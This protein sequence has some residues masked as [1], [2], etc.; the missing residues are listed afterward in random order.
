[1]SLE[2]K[3]NKNDRKRVLKNIIIHRLSNWKS[4]SPGLYKK[5][6]WACD[7]PTL[8]CN[9]FPFS[10]D[11]ELCWRSLN[12]FKDRINC[13]FINHHCLVRDS[14]W[15]VLKHSQGDDFVRHCPVTNMIEIRYLP[16]AGWILMKFFIVI[17]VLGNTFPAS[18]TA[19]VS[20][21]ATCLFVIQSQ[22]TLD[23]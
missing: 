10:S 4:M 18:V 21:C 11:V 7:P 20:I 5:C 22:I 13:L 8:L 23:W 2:N 1:M 14:S 9:E 16:R 15:Q 3:N 6:E 12:P 17:A 19:I